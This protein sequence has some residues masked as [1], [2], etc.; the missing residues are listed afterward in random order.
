[1]IEAFS[2]TLSSRLVNLS[3]QLRQSSTMTP[4]P[5]FVKDLRNLF[6]GT[7]AFRNFSTLHEEKDFN[8]FHVGVTINPHPAKRDK[9]GEDAATVTENFIALADG[10][11]GWADSGVDPANYSRTLC[12]N[13]RGLILYDGGQRY[14]CNPR[15]LCEEAAKMTTEMGSATCVIASLDKEAPVIYTS[16]LGDSGYLLLRMSDEESSDLLTVFRSV[17]QTHGFNFPYQIGTGGD[18][19]NKADATLHSV[20]HNDIIVIGTD[21]LF[22]NLF[23]DQIKDLIKPFMQGTRDLNDP[24]K[25]ADVIA[26]SAEQKS[27]DSNY[28][29]PFA[30]AAQEQMYSYMGG[31]QDDITVAV[32]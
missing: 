24:S 4:K 22:D 11:G 1:M 29:S 3:F 25:V 17:E 7:A 8:K 30:K 12:K 21:G 28:L 26:E 14:M 23:D 18:D 13:I 9:G 27:R 19:P 32:A 15:L 5:G 10:V 31:K 20:Q 2:S 16:N 6:K